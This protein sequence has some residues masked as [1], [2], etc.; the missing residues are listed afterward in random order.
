M[1]TNIENLTGSG[2]GDTLTG[3]AGDNIFEG[4][5]GSDDIDG[6]KR[7]LIQPLMPAQVRSAD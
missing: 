2:C 6:L 7:G 4:R 1:L 5:G 3:D